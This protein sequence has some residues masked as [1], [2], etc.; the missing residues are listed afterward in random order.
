MTYPIQ[1]P[2][3]V[4]PHLRHRAT[5]L[6]FSETQIEFYFSGLGF[7]APGFDLDHDFAEVGLMA[8]PGSPPETW[9][10]ERCPCG[11]GRLGPTEENAQVIPFP[12]RRSER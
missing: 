6:G 12:E 2:A 9:T 11:C 8:A 1:G 3:K 7:L 4:P 10:V 5:A